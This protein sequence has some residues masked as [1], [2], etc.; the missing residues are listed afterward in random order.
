MLNSDL[1]VMAKTRC[2][3]KEILSKELRQIC[4]EI[5][6]LH[7]TKIAVGKI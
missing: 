5:Y 3:L 4:L 6:L 1:N 2:S 7:V